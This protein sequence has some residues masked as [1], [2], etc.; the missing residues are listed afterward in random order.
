MFSEFE[1][2][3]V[4]QDSCGLK[5]NCIIADKVGELWYDS[6]RHAPISMAEALSSPLELD[7]HAAADWKEMGILRDH[8]VRRG[9]WIVECGCHHG[10]T[11]IMLASWTGKGGFV[12][13]FDAV[14]LNAAVARRNL[15]L[16]RIENAA[17]YCAAI[18]GKTQIVNCFNES[19]VVV[20]PGKRVSPA[21]TLMVK[22]EDVA[23]ERI[24]VLKLDVEGCELDI[25]ETSAN[26][27]T[28]VP[29]L[30][31]ELHVDLLPPDGVERVLAMLAG[32]GLH[33]LWE[34]GTFEPYKAQKLTERVHLFS[35]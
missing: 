10:L 17:V 27:L 8:L 23:P 13:A 24:D 19:N 22:L 1:P 30:A 28:R 31:I 9:D 6:P 5:F 26:L 11:T 18:G 32:R 4:R 12:F 7:R 34:N 29:R 14:P 33:V 25:L 3:I 21:S 35:F 15:E 16:N 20:K 2:R